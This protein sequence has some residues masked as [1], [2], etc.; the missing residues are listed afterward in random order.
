MSPEMIEMK[1]NITTKSDIWSLGSTV[2][3]LM[4]GNPPYHDLD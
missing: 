3:E 2:I 4:T 1:G